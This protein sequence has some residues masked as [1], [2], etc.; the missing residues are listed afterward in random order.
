M[1]NEEV[2][3][4]LQLYFIMG[5]TNCTE[6]PEKVLFQAIS[7]GISMFQFREKG[8]DALTGSEKKNLAR[9]LQQLC[10][11]HGIPFI[12]NDDIELALALNADGVHIGQDDEDAGAVRKILGEGK[13]VGVSA[14]TLAE[15]EKAIEDG[16]DY[17]GAGPIYPTRTKTDAKPVKGTSL[18]EEVRNCGILIPIVGI[19]GITAENARAV[20]E[21]GADGVSVITSI[22][23]AEDVY[24]SAAA[25]KKSVS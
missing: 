15:V 7:G 24:K 5:S 10:K 6:D 21:A 13:I 22:S 17:I 16:A 8:T 12:I 9:K 18:L 1:W 11:D 2:R 25:L 4:K 19:G 14:H 23:L 20:I 3:A